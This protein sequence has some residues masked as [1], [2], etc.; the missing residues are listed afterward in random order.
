[1][2][3]YEQFH[4][5]R[6]PTCVFYCLPYERVSIYIVWT[7]EYLRKH[8]VGRRFRASPTPLHRWFINIFVKTATSAYHHFPSLFEETGTRLYFVAMCE[9]GPSHRIY[10]LNYAVSKYLQ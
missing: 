2:C 9:L 1:M 4:Y 10:I 3:V 6:T 8:Y 7:S 5:L